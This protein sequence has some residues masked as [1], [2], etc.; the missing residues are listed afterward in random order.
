M[1]IMDVAAFLIGFAMPILT[2]L[3]LGIAIRLFIWLWKGF[4]ED[5]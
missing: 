2:I 1:N 4:D 3:F 5:N